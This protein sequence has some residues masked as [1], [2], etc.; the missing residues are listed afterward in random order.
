M[1]N[2]FIIKNSLYIT[3]ILAAIV[4]FITIIFWNQMPITQRL[5]GIYYV[6]IAFHEWEEMKFPGGFV[7]LV[8]KLTGMPVKD[9]TIAKFILFLI[10]VYMLLIPFCIPSLHWLLIG[11]LVLGIIE[12]I[13]HLA[14]AKVN[15]KDKFY[16]PG[17]FTAIFLMI[18]IDIYS[19]YYL[20]T[21]E[22]FS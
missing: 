1:S 7:E 17:M 13:A 5:I 14:V 9:M 3:S 2:K 21:Q 16:S 6:L 18:P 12:P 11:P 15:S 8:I 19:I 22:T 4:L 10:T 20:V